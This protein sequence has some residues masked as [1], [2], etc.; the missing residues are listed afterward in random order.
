MIR[1]FNIRLSKIYPLN[2]YLVR[3]AF[4]TSTHHICASSSHPRLAK[5][6]RNMNSCS[7]SMIQTQSLD[8]PLTLCATFLVVSVASSP[9][10]IQTVRSTIAAVQDLVKNVG[11]RDT[12]AALTCIVGIGSD[13][14]DVLTSMPRPTELHPFPVIQGAVHTAV[15]TPGDI[16]FHIRSERHDLCFE[17]ERQLMDRLGDSVSVNDK[18]VGF[19]YF[20]M[21]DLLGFVDGTAN[22]VGAEIESSAFVGTEDSSA[23]GGSYVVVQKYVH[24]MKSWKA[25]TVAEQEAIIGRTKMENIELDDA[26]S[27]QLSHKSLATIEKD[28]QEYDILRHNMPFGDPSKNEFGTY[29]IGYSRYLWTIEEMIRRMFIGNPPSKHDRLLDFSRPLTGT[30]F[31]VPAPSL[32]GRLESD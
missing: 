4:D 30:T 10:S 15:S 8:A 22:P 9:E 27:C 7:H 28:G 20:D 12:K 29:F 13:I 11:F 23:T 5:L 24:D 14:W 1:P 19:R 16:F 3:R 26:D 32:L 18:T 21:R 25:L 17:L 31:F 2:S 6:A